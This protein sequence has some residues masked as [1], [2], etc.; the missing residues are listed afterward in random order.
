MKTT[1]YRAAVILNRDG[2]THETTVFFEHVGSSTEAAFS[3]SLQLTGVWFCQLGQLRVIN[4]W[5]E[6]VLLA[7]AIGT[8]E[9]GDQRL[10][11][12]SAWHGSPI[13]ADPERTLMLVSPPLLRRLVL[14]QQQLPIVVV[15]TA[16]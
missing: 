1:L 11:E 15:H 12:V 7:K 8:P 9:T 14:A 5:A 3:L 6:T 13:Y 4:A 10:F 2:E 16:G